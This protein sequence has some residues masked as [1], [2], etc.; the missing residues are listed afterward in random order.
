MAHR[1]TSDVGAAR[2]VDVVAA[3]PSGAVVTGTVPGVHDTRVVRA[4]YSKLGPKHRLRAWVQV[5]ALAASAE[6]PAGSREGWHAATVG[7]APRRH[8]PAAWRRGCGV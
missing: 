4:E 5:L 6:A 7:R 2:A 3:L 1:V 8:P